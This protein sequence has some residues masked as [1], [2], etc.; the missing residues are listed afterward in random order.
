MFEIGCVDEYANDESTHGLFIGT[1]CL[2][3]LHHFF[4]GAGFR[5][6]LILFNV[7]LGLW[8]SDTFE[9]D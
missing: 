6:G 8:Q 2:I 3:G 1:W 4:P 5:L 9:K 7:C